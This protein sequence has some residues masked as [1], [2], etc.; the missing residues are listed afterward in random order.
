M[1]LCV[2]SPE[3]DEWKLIATIS[4]FCL[5]PSGGGHS[6]SSAN[7]NMTGW[8]TNFQG[9]SSHKPVRSTVE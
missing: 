7:R 6:M 4:T 3:H 2:S 9:P 5:V 8:G 1:S